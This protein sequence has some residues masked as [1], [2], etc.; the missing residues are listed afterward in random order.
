ME[1]QYKDLGR[2]ANAQEARSC[3]MTT[4]TDGHWYL[5]ILSSGF[6]VST[7]L[8]TAES[9]FCPFPDGYIDYPFGSIGSRTGKI[10]FGAGQ[11][12]YEFDPSKKAY[13]FSAKLTDRV[14][15]CEA[16]APFEAAD[17]SIWFGAY[18][19]TRLRRFDPK[20]RTVT[21]HGIMGKGQSYLSSI[22]QDKFGWIYGGLGTTAP[23]VAAYCPETGEHRILATSETPG[24]CAEVR[25]SFDGTV[26]GALNGS[27]HGGAYSPQKSWHRL[28]KGIWGDPVSEP[29]ETLYSFSSF[30]AIHCPFREHP[31]ILEQDLVD[32]RLVYRH[33]ETGKETTLTLSYDVAGAEL[34]PIT[35]GP[36]GKVYGTTNHPIQIFTHDPETDSLTNYGRSPFARHISGWG[37]I[38]AYASQGSILVGAAYCGGYVVRI[39]TREPIC[40]R[41][42]DRNPHCEGA[43]REVLRP[44]SAAA[45]ADGRTVLFSGF[46]IYGKAGGGMIRYDCESR[47]SSLIPNENLLPGHSIL[48]ILPLGT[49]RLLC[50][51]SIEV[52]GG[53]LPTAEEA[54][55]FEYDLTN[56]QVLRSWVPVPGAREIAHLARDGQGRIHGISNGGTLITLDPTGKELL[57]VQDLS[58]YGTPVRDGMKTAPDGTV[59]G[60]LTGGIYRIRPNASAPEF[61]PRPPCPIT[62]G[63]ALVKDSLYFGSNSHLWKVGPL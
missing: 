60:L 44:R 46:N 57:S 49:D 56:Q 62:C 52:P 58:A 36:D 5:V 15:T 4:G 20:T 42:D 40:R 9:T 50:G 54:A 8:H 18:D 22:A 34:S 61:L 47:S 30:D 21:D 55:L 23:T 33:P 7:D 12:F 14:G 39:D 31:Q 48:A 43:F 16:W 63:M 28:E 25:V 27:S 53:G 2:V 37:N 59:Y 38:C 6:V 3:A 32:H 19:I 11:M 45:L 24:E 17:G 26:Y 1:M 41:P 29:F 51:T 13:T 35:A 10:Y